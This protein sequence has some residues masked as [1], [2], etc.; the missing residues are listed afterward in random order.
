MTAAKLPRAF[1]S[2]SE[3]AIHKS[4][5]PGIGESGQIESAI[6]VIGFKQQ[7]EW[8]F[9]KDQL[10]ERELNREARDA[11]TKKGIGEDS[12]DLPKSMQTEFQIIIKRSDWIMLQPRAYSQAAGQLT[13]EI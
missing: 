9:G 3:E 2:T 10:T 8:R 11:P 6:L 13:C 1:W 12:L 7:A 4:H 5:D